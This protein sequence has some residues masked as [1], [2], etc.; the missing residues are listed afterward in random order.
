MGRF[1]TKI[2]HIAGLPYVVCPQIGHRI[3]APAC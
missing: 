3:R 2:A 1:V